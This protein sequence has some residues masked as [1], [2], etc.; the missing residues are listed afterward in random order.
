MR[1]GVYGSWRPLLAEAGTLRLIEG[2]Q[3]GNGA[4]AAS[5]EPPADNE[6]VTAAR[7]EVR[8]RTDRRL[9]LGPE[10]L[11]EPA[12]DMLLDLYLAQVAGRHVAVSSLCIA[13]GVPTTTALRWIRMLERDGLLVRERDRD[14]GRR[15]F[16]K[17]SAPAREKVELLMRRMIDR[18]A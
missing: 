13:S 11:A 1:E 17:L 8:R 6:L 4:R 15:S 12:W 2:G 7:E 3:Q 18:A 16:I 14:D 9:V 10:L 5:V